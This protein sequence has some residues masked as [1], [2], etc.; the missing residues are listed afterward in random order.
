MSFVADIASIGSAVLAVGF[1][2]WMLNSSLPTKTDSPVRSHQIKT[3]AHAGV[4][5]FQLTETLYT[6]WSI[7]MLISMAGWGDILVVI[8]GLEPPTPAL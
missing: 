3:P 4:F 2:L 7:A 5:I 1:S 6:S 8:G